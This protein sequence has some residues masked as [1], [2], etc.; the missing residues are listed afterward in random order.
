MAHGVRLENHLHSI[1]WCSSLFE[2]DFLFFLQMIDTKDNL[3]WK[4]QCWTESWKM[5]LITTLLIEC[6]VVTRRDVEEIEMAACSGA[7]W[8]GLCNDLGI[9]MCFQVPLLSLDRSP[10][11]CFEDW[12]W[13]SKGCIQSVSTAEKAIHHYYW[14]LLEL[15]QTWKVRILM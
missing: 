11:F 2:N 4:K 6:P 7:R 8:L 5:H 14:N 10:P 1:M 12:P 15:H 9:S 3:F 13:S